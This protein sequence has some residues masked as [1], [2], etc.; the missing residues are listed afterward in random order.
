LA[1]CS[2][3]PRFTDET[4][5]DDLSQICK[6]CEVLRE[7]ETYH[8]EPI[9]MPLDGGYEVGVSGVYAAGRWLEPE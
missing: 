1:G 2:D 8:Q 9:H 3:D 7:C 4:C 5:T 6:G